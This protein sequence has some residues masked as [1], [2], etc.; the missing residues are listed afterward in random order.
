MRGIWQRIV[1]RRVVIGG[2]EEGEEEGE[3]EGFRS[4]IV[5]IVGRKDI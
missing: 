3:E 4:R 5:I 2:G 1:Q